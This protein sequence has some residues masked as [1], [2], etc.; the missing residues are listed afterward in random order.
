[1]Y[2]FTIKTRLDLW[3]GKSIEIAPM[4]SKSITIHHF[5]TLE[6]RG[7]WAKLTF[8]KRSGTVTKDREKTG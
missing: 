4:A 5:T 1:M 8:A 2:K 7:N 3:S 6:K